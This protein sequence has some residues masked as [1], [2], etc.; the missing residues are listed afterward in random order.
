MVDA[1]K[2]VIRLFKDREELAVFQN[3]DELRQL[4]TYYLNRP[5]E[6]LKIA[7]AGRKSVLEKHTYKHRVHELLI[8]ANQ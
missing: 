3:V 2:D 8:I 1:Q 6:R 5:E 7:E 4:I